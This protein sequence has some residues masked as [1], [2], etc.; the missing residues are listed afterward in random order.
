MPLPA[1]IP[2]GFWEVVIIVAAVAVLLGVPM[3]FVAACV[4]LRRIIREWR[5]RRRRGRRPGGGRGS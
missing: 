2:L 4:W 1:I 3:L 5:A